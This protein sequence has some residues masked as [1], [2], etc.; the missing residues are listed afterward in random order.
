VKYE[1]Y[2]KKLDILNEEFE[3]GLLLELQEKPPTN[4]HGEIMKSISRERRKV[5]F[6]NYRIYA[7]AIAAV[8]VFAVVINRP[9]ILEKLNF[10]KNVKI[11]Q[12]QNLL[13][14]ENTD[15]KNNINHNEVDNPVASNDTNAAINNPKPQGTEA[16]TPSSNNSN[17]TTQQK[18]TKSNDKEDNNDNNTKI[19]SEDNISKADTSPVEES[20][21]DS[22][23]ESEANQLNMANILGFL[24][25]KEPDVNYE[26]V[27]DVNKSPILNFITENY[28]EKLS[29]PNTYKLS[30]EQFDSLDKLLINNNIGKKVINESAAT[31]SKVVKINFVNYHI[32][33]NDSKS[34]VVKFLE[35]QEKSVKID[36]NTYKIALGN[37]SELDKIINSSGIKKE[38]I[39]K[40]DDE[41]IIFKTLIINYE[42]T[43]DSSQT[44]AVGF[45]KDNEKCVPI[46]DSIYKL[47]R[48][49]FNEFKELITDPSI[50]VKVLNETNNQDIIVKVNNI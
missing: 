40:A 8:L 1:E 24:Y 36:D 31:T 12:Q 26:I 47:S 48:D 14:N 49:S 50:G 45:L 38:F 11:T 37:M 46:K 18:D 15:P 34:D 29:A 25:F 7:P 17:Y 9:E 33:I 5:N 22:K 28:E 35:D 30:I 39:S 43:I 20:T 2:I 16:S 4:L 3:E 32:T 13:N 21:A 19:A 41:Y 23:N 10:T 6:L 27:L 44:A 42:I